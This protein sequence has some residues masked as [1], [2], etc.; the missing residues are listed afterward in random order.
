MSVTYTYVLP[1]KEKVTDYEFIKMWEAKGALVGHTQIMCHYLRSYIK[2]ENHKAKFIRPDDDI[3]NPFE[4]CGE[5]EQ[6]IIILA[7]LVNEL[8]KSPA[9]LISTFCIGVED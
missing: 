3:L 9:K 6:S 5:N 4:L 1:A 7:D 2:Y 8:L